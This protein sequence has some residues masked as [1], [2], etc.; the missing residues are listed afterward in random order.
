MPVFGAWRASVEAGDF[1]VH[2]V[3]GPSRLPLV[4]DLDETLL[5]AKSQ[6]Q[7]NSALAAARARRVALAAQVQAAAPGSAAGAELQRALAAAG[8]EEGQLAADL[9]LLQQYAERDAVTHRGQEY[10]AQ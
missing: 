9:S 3:L 10:A 8:R 1:L 7:L 6:S 4:F 2:R 5:V